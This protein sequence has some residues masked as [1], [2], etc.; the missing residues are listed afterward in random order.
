MVAAA[1]LLL[2]LTPAV[3]TAARLSREGADWRYADG[4]AAVFDSLRPG[5]EVRFSY[6]ASPSA[7]PLVLA[8]TTVTV[9][10]GQGSIALTTRYPVPTMTLA[11]TVSYTA[12]L[13]GGAVEVTR[14]V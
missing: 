5:V 3:S 12:K 4:V 6:G 10:D 8:G 2:V 1:V 11:P 7:D 9:Y 13:V 14:V